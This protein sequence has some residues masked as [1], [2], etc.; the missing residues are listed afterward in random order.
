MCPP[1][2][3]MHRQSS[4]N[5]AS[6]SFVD[7]FGVAQVALSHGLALQRAANDTLASSLPARALATFMRGALTDPTPWRLTESPCFS[8]C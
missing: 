3:E 7:E 5:S 2:S 6:V 1:F 4:P 8:V